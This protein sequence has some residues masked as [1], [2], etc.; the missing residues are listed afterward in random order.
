METFLHTLACLLPLFNAIVQ[1]VMNYGACISGDSSEAHAD[2]MLQL[3]KRAAR[4]IADAPCDAP[5][6]A[7]V[8]DLDIIAFKQRVSRAKAA[9]IFKAVNGMLPVYIARKFT[10]FSQVYSHNTRNCHRHLILPKVN[11][12]FGGR[13]FF[14]TGA[15]TLDKLCW[16]NA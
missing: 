16:N 3:Q 13:T 9:L 10:P 2:T 12:S 4:I 5:L 1:P 14:F 15:T 8:K 6:E 7:L 11:L